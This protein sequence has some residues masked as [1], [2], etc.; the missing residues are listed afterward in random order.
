[1]LVELG[2]VATDDVQSWARFARRL[3]VE[4]RVDPGDLDGVATEDLLDQWSQ[5]ID[6]WVTTS[7]KSETF[8]WSRVLD[9]E[10]GEFLLHGLDRCFHSPDMQRRVT[11]QESVAHRSFTVHVFQGFLDGLDSEGVAHEQYA[12]QIRASLGRS[13]DGAS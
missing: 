2:P 1:M 8:R 10:L 9:P 13:L 3:I 6:D 7:T 4:L 5:L 12:D 11:E